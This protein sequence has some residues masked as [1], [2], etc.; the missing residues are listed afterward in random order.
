IAWGIV[1]C[2]L[3]VLSKWALVGRIRPGQRFT[4]HS[5]EHQ[6]WW[7]VQRLQSVAGILF[8]DEIRRSRLIVFFYRALGAK[9]GRDV[10]LNTVRIADPDL[11]TVGAGS[12]VNEHADL[13]GHEVVGNT[14]VFGSGVTIGRGTLVLP[15]AM[16]RPQ[17]EVEDGRVV[18]A[19]ATGMHPTSC[20]RTPLAPPTPVR[21]VLLQVTADLVSLYV[22]AVAACLASFVAFRVFSH[23]LEMAGVFPGSYNAPLG[24]SQP[25]AESDMA[26]V[27][28]ASVFL[29]TKAYLPM[30]LVFGGANSASAY[31]LLRTAIT[32]GTSGV[33]GAIGMAAVSAVVFFVTHMVVS[34]ALKWLLVQRFTP[35]EGVCHTCSWLGFRKQI[36]DRLIMSAMMRAVLMFNGNL[37][38]SLWLWAL[39]G[40]VGNRVSVMLNK[41]IYTEPELLTLSD[42][43]HVGFASSTYCSIYTAP[44][45]FMLRATSVGK[46]GLNGAGSVMLP[47]AILPEGAALGPNTRLSHADPVRSGALHL[48]APE[49]VVAGRYVSPSRKLSLLEQFLYFTAPLPLAFFSSCVTIN[50]GFWPMFG[51]AYIANKIELEAAEAGIGERAWWVVPGGASWLAPLVWLVFG[52]VLIATGAAVKWLIIGRQHS[53][54]TRLWSVYHYRTLLVLHIQVQ[55]HFLF[56]DTLRR[57]KLFNCYARFLGANVGRDADVATPYFTDHD[58]ISIGDRAVVEED[59]I[60]HPQYYFEGDM[61]LEPISIGPGSYA[62]PR[63]ILLGGSTL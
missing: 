20:N 1:L 19:L 11:L 18:G 22:V 55:A 54:S 41:N 28:F 50:A 14:V 34:V 27:C 33:T 63:S 26:L 44:Y 60:P 7:V 58:L 53:S 59:C 6:R 51:L 49:P 56:V 39:G 8:V 2:L 46:R 38:N 25:L 61:R 12:T 3:V 30:L 24:F 31:S 4:T 42:D 13:G 48:G 57:S 32:G 62:G 47:G 29:F 17:A 52:V 43:M 40:P 23:L 15:S 37:G 35:I 45:S 9:L 10:F 16:L 36:T 21:G 5:E